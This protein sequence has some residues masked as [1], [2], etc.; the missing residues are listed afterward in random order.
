MVFSVRSKAFKSAYYHP[1]RSE[2]IEVDSKGF[3]TLYTDNGEYITPANLWL[4][5]LVNVKKVKDSSS[6]V[7]ALKSY[8]NYLENNSLQWDEFPSQKSLKPTYLFRNQCL[9]HLAKTGAIKYSTASLY[10]NLII[11]FYSWAIYEK[12]LKIDE[13]SAPFEY[14]FIKAGS[15]NNNKFA[16]RNFVVRT[17]DLKIRSPKLSAEQS[18]NPLS[19]NELKCFI[20]A[21]NN[22]NEG[23]KIHQL[24]QLQCGLR[25][26][27]ACTFPASLIRLPTASENRIEIEIGP[28][29]GVHTKFGNIRKIEVTSVL[30]KRMYKYLISEKRNMYLLKSSPFDFEPLLI[31]SR[32]KAYLS[33][34]VQKYFSN[35]RVIIRK[36]FHLT[37]AHRTHDLRA[38]YATF[39]LAS[40]LENGVNP[41]DAMKLLMGWMGHQDEKTIWRYL[42]YLKKRQLNEE[43]LCV[44]DSIVDDALRDS[45]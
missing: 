35:L 45:E 31:N 16:S 14:E 11:Q 36:K 32:G 29:N 15:G 38:T 3:D 8:W 17:T 24:L 12:L 42:T 23:F 39:R 1:F 40:M 33:G 4:N 20:K 5:H 22:C 18:L 41:V 10:M 13:T 26:E 44:L 19:E 7:R 43:V 9:L 37:F 6:T 28:H 21:L 30:M 2:V 27:E 25:I 34:T